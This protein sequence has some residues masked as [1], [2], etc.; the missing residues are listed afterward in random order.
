VAAVVTPTAS[1]IAVLVLIALM[2]R[3]PAPFAVL[4]LILLIP[5]WL[6]S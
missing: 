4:R 3:A 6:A 1:V 5:W 2:I